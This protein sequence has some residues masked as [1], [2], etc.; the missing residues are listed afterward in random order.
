MDAS[1]EA[2]L[3]ARI[4]R[5]LQGTL[6]NELEFEAEAILAEEAGCTKRHIIFAI[7]YCRSQGAVWS[8]A[9][10]EL[11]ARLIREHNTTDR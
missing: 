7:G 1:A 2:A 4:I 9:V 10:R 8:L 11:Q 5:R 6:P 3:T